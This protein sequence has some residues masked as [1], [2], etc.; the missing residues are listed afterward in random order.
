MKPRQIAALAQLSDAALFESLAE[1]MAL[2][3]RNARDLYRVSR[4]LEKL[5]SP[6]AGTI[7]RMV[8]E[9]EAAKWLM[10]LDAARCTKAELGGHLRKFYSHLARGIYAEACSW[11]S[12]T[13]SEHL[14]YVN[15]SRRGLY[16]DGPTDVDWIFRNRILAGREE[17]M[18]VDFVEH[19]DGYEWLSPSD[20][21]EIAVGSVVGARSDVIELMDAMV[22]SGYGSPVGLSLVAKRWRGRELPLEMHHKRV[23]DLMLEE[24]EEFDSEGVGGVRT[25]QSMHD[26]VWQY[27]WPLHSADLREIRV[28]PEELQEVRSRH[29]PE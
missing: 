28:T 12:A 29:W 13:Y 24:L 8:A 4:S 2:T 11:R 14:G 15:L 16:L 26:L 27:T 10:L 5:T 19:E 1:G 3:Y 21:P 6:Q 22:A 7:L 17:S 23:R 9:E 20:S 18:Y 25:D